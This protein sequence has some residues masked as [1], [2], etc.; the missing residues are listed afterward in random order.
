MF[1]DLEIKGNALPH[2]TLCLTYDDGPGET[3]SG[4]PGPRTSEIGA[5]LGERRVPATFFVVGKFA[6]GLGHVLG[7]LRAAGHLVANHTFHHPHLLRD[8]PDRDR[9]VDQLLLTDA[10]IKPHVHGPTVYFRP[11]YGAWRPDG[12]PRS[13]LADR[14][15]GSRRLAAHVGPILWDIGGA[16]WTYWRDRRSPGECARDYLTQIERAGRGIVMMHDSTADSD[17]VRDNN[18]TFELTRQ[19]IPLLQ[20]RGFRFVR[21]DAV[22][23]VASAA[24]VS[25]QAALQA[26]GGLFVSPRPRSDDEV[27]AGIPP[28]GGYERFGV[29]DLDGGRVAIRAANGRFLSA[30]RNA[31]GAV[32]ASGAV[33]GEREVLELELLGEDLVALRTAGGSYFGCAPRLGGRLTADFKSRTASSIFKLIRGAPGPAGVPSAI[34]TARRQLR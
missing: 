33:V 32:R 17:P 1:L 31:G 16:D 29:V 27:W 12:A 24:A 26:P 6:S 19:L 30:P 4:G 15:N 21:L 3:S 14:L 2:R 23:Q 22:P 11:P 8:V 20:E 18:Q 7:Q 10:R 34:S 13:E 9:L 25:F 5:Y 28:A